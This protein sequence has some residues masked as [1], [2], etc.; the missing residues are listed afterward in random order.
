MSLLDPWRQARAEII[1]SRPTYTPFYTPGDYAVTVGNTETGL[2]DQVPAEVAQTQI[3]RPKVAGD[4][5]SDV[6]SYSA[7][8]GVE[9]SM[10]APY[11]YTEAAPTVAETY[12]A[13]VEAVTVENVFGPYSNS[14]VA[15]VM[16]PQDPGHSYS[17]LGEQVS[18]TPQ[19]PSPDQSVPDYDTPAA[20]DLSAPAYTVGPDGRYT[21][22][23]PDPSERGLLDSLSGF[24]YA[25]AGNTYQS[26]LYDQHGQRTDTEQYATG[27]SARDGAQAVAMGMPLGGFFASMIGNS[28]VGDLSQVGPYTADAFGDFRFGAPGPMGTIMS[29]AGFAITPDNYV[30]GGPAMNDYSGLYGLGTV[31]NTGI[32]ATPAMFDDF[33]YKGGAYGYGYGSKADGTFGSL[34]AWDVGD[35][36]GA[37][38]QVASDPNATYA[39]IDDLD[40]MEHGNDGGDGGGGDKVICGELNRQGIMD[41]AT[42]Q[43]DLQY[44]REHVHN[45]TKAGYLLWARPLVKLMRRSKIVTKIVTPPAMAWAK[46]MAK[47]SVGHGNGSV[48]GKIMLFTIAPVCTVLGAILWS[49]PKYDLGE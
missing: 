5:G 40:E 26:G 28:R 9:T 20:M 16:G 3:Y 22:V 13:P 15:A 46:E 17:Y 37:S 41:D 21:A 43:G 36:A 6:D 49:L 10:S 34:D 47:R 14:S 7:P 31:G 23:D 44:Q 30:W 2:V 24:G 18:S 32:S 33:G 42:Y 39:D 35:V 8:L 1:A 19:G 11:S 38:E 4:Y 25:T 27:K 45:F 29:P 48:A 12:A